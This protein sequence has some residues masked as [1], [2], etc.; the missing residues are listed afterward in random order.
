ME[1]LLKC[2]AAGAE[3]RQVRL[4]Q[5]PASVGSGAVDVQLP[6]LPESAGELRYAADG[7]FLF[8]P[9]ADLMV[10][11]HGHSHEGGAVSVA[12]GDVLHVGDWRVALTVQFPAARQG[13]GARR[14]QWFS[15][16]LLTLFV[17]FELLVA[18]WLPGYIR[19]R[20][21]WGQ[22]LARQRTYQLVDRLRA[23]RKRPPPAEPRAASTR[24]FVLD[25]LERLTAYLAEHGDALDGSR[26]RE[27]QADLHFYR[28]V[29]QRLEAG[30]LY[31]PPVTLHTDSALRRLL[32]PP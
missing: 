12:N 7:R 28:E 16:A 32:P 17:L 19:S 18:T 4:G 25:E 24:Q 29:L 31:P 13:P 15:L 23:W 2:T 5:L 20:E 27:L 1:I 8:V 14:L 22:E 30:T 3:P 26:L 11:V 21:L 6:G 9:V 10:S